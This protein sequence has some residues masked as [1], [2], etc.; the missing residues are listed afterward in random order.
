LRNLLADIQDFMNR[1]ETATGR[2]PLIYTSRMWS[3]SDMMN[4]PKTLSEYP[5]WTVYH[6]GASP[7]DPK[8]ISMG[9]WGTQWQILQYAED[10]KYGWHLNPYREPGV[11][12][13]GIDFDAFNGSLHQLRG[14]ADLGR[15]G[16]SHS[17]NF[18]C[19]A[20]GEP[21]GTNTVFFEQ[22]G[23]TAPMSDGSTPLTA[24]DPVLLSDATH[25]YAYY[26]GA[27]DRIVEA[28]SET[29]D[30]T[31]VW[32]AHEISSSAPAALWDPRAASVGEIRYVAYA[33]GDGE[34]YL[35]KSGTS[36]WVV[37][38][39]MLGN[40]GL[41]GASTVAT[42]QPAVFITRNVAHVVGR[43]GTEGHMVDVWNDGQSWH[44]EDLTDNAM[45][46]VATYSPCAY[47][48]PAGGYSIAYRGLHGVMFLIT[49]SDNVTT[50]LTDLTAS[51]SRRAARVV[52]HPTCFVLKDI[53]HIVYRSEDGKLCEF[54]KD[55][56][57]WHF[58]SVCMDP[59]HSAAADPVAV[60]DAS[61]AWIGFRG[62]DG[63]I[64][65]T[66]YNGT[67]WFCANGP[68]PGIDGRVMQ[69]T[70]SLLTEED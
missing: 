27:G 11:A 1:L 32:R 22:Y 30:P 40:A 70:E 65:H 49:R 4:D 24:A 50:N 16:V 38:K 67:D 7:A 41:S 8:R 57:G 23:R 37:T 42:G 46:P 25:L 12:V 53:P 3:D 6:P 13:P 9:G 54:W 61:F 26:R 20:A 17:G 55:V 52:G 43:V 21:D 48:D 51:S 19:L 47:E 18:L 28:I 44:A 45:A 10:G 58:G 62:S 59:D 2:T 33:G 69:T 36:G 15:V 63:A 39:S 34:W 5:L 60:A 35:L 56:A 29:A 31:S 68:R 14:L 66:R 64:H